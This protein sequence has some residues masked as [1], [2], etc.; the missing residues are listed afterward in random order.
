MNLASVMPLAKHHFV[1]SMMDMALKSGIAGFGLAR[2]AFTSCNTAFTSGF[3]TTPS[4]LRLWDFVP[5]WHFV[6]SK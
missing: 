5:I 6:L 4:G 2:F 3:I 1:A